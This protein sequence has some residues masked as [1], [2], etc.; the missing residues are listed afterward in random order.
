MLRKVEMIMM[1]KWMCL[2]LT[3]VLALSA[4][5]TFAAEVD[6]D[7]AYVQEKGVLVVG[8]T[9]FAP[10]DYLDNG[11]WIGFDADMAKAFA[12]SLGLKVEFIEIDWDN[13]LLELD[14]KS[15]DCIWNG[16]TLTEEIMG[17]TSCSKP[18]ANNAQV[19]VVPK[20]VADQ[21]QT[22]EAAAE[23][24]FAVEAGSAGQSQAE[25]YGFSF[26]PVSAQTDAVM[27]VKA[28]SSDAAI[29]DALMAAAVVG[30]GA[31]VKDI[32]FASEPRRDVLCASTPP[33]NS[34]FAVDPAPAE[35]LKMQGQEVY[36]FAVSHS[37]K[38]IQA[39]LAAHGLQ[40]EDVD[41]YVLH[42]ANMRILEAVRTRLK[43][44]PEHF[45]H[46]IER[47][48]NTSSATIPVLLDEMN[49]AGQLKPG[50]RAILNAFG[51][52]LCTGTA[53]IEF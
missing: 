11:E 35:Y 1:K 36:K 28:G 5:G 51:A 43:V 14:N 15:I 33:G 7:V 39:M 47:T 9:D 29:I 19:I 13:K 16:M 22:A 26:T 12:A 49:R 20:D 4:V 38:D 30:E 45:P 46:N 8:I 24:Q 41:F 31:G 50:C 2:I 21:Y 48:G 10:M 17:A 6:A 27:E 34:P 42:Q 40:P 44:A 3:A 37:F 25:A 23:L 18:Y 52:G 32:R 53:L